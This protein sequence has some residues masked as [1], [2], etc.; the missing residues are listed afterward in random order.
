MTEGFALI[1]FN[2]GKFWKPVLAPV[3]S[4][5]LLAYNSSESINHQTVSVIIVIW[6]LQI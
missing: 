2:V 1:P 5:T 3:V 6:K 4:R